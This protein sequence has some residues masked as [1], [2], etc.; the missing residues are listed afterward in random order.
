MNQDFFY[1]LQYYKLLEENSKE[2]V[3]D[4]IKVKVFRGSTV[5]IFRQLGISNSYYSKIIPA[6]RDLQCVTQLKRGARGVDSVV[7]VHHPPREIEFLT[8]DTKPLTADP[9]SA[10][11]AQQIEEIHE[12]LGGGRFDVVAAIEN[13]DQRLTKLESERK[14]GG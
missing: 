10:K 9:H 7:L 1:A 11:L 8:R 3:I 5:R 2:E 14:T 12:S 13:L 4:K 6:L